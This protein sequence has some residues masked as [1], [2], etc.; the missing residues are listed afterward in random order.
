MKLKKY[1]LA[2][3]GLHYKKLLRGS[4]YIYLFFSYI[5]T[6]WILNLPQNTFTCNNIIYKHWFG[7]LFILL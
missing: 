1:F 5:S 3:Y 2:V 6:E 7:N 4:V